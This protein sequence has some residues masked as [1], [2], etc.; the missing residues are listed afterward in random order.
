M[1]GKTNFSRR[2]SVWKSLTLGVICS[3]VMAWPD[4]PWP[5]IF[6]DRS[7]LLANAIVLF[8]CRTKSIFV[9]N[10]KLKVMLFFCLRL[11]IDTCKTISIEQVSGVLTMPCHLVKT[12]APNANVKFELLLSS[13]GL[14]LTSRKH[15]ASGHNWLIATFLPLPNC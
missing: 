12:R 15:F 6:Y 9:S 2:L 5:P 14:L 1:E 3:S 11:K 8:I 4:W 13:S 10:F 7:T